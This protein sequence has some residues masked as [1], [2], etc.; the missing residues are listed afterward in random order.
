MSES[1]LL[2]LQSWIHDLEEGRLS[3]EHRT[4]LEAALAGSEQAR[5]LYV[6]RM[7]LGAGLCKLADEA[8]E[9]EKAPESGPEHVISF[10]RPWPLSAKLALAASLVLCGLVLALALRRVSDAP[11][12]AQVVAE[13]SDAGCAVLVDAA[14]A[15]WEEGSSPWQVGMSVP[16]GKLRLRSGLARLEFYSGASVTLEGSSELEIVSVN[17]ARCS[18]GQMRVHVPPHARGFKLTTPDA[19]VVDLGTEFGLKVSPEGR[20]QVHVFDGEVEVL[21]PELHIATLDVGA[22]L[23]MEITLSHGRGYVSADKNKA[24]R[25]GVIGVIPIDSIYTPVYKVNYTVE[26]TRVG[27]SS[28]YDKLTLEVWTDTTIAA[29]DAVSLGAKILCDHFALF[30]DLSDTLG[31]KSTVVEKAQDSKDKMLELTIEELDLSVRSFNCLK[32]ANINTVEDLISKTE[33]EMMK[34][35]NLG[36]K[37][38]EEVINKLAMMGLSL[39]SEDNN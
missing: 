11:A 33:D 3:G 30:T 20:A 1:E 27:A 9:A 29:R 28:D 22:T 37:S 16:A 15:E 5:R 24:A 31:D 23:S 38:L 7:Q 6:Q 2:Q 36:R 34:V 21:N 10:R 17:E 18:R 13:T 32:R 19:E 8:Q 26:S 35:R 39:A 4:L 14:G 12:S 25:P